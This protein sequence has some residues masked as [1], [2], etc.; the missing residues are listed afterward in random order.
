MKINPNIIAAAILGASIVI[1]T[2]VFRMTLRE[3]HN[4][5]G[6]Y[7]YKVIESPDGQMGTTRIFDTQKGILYERLTLSN[8][9]VRISS[10]ISH[11]TIELE[12]IV[13]EKLSTTNDVD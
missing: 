5:T 11:A 8:P 2:I 13:D 10:V 4:D 12:K 1:G 7:T 9:K 6:R 3:I